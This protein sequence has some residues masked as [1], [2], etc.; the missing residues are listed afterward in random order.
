MMKICLQEIYNLF[1]L[2]GYVQITIIDLGCRTYNEDCCD[3]CNNKI[4]A[5]C[6]E[7]Y[8]KI[9]ND[10]INRYIESNYLN[11]Y[12]GGKIKNKTSYKIYKRKTKKRRKNHK[13]YRNKTRKLL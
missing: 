11:N 5:E 10:N 2:W 13:K 8:K 4:C 9:E 3:K 7:I 1:T 6:I 12:G